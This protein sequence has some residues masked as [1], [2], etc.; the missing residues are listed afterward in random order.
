[1]FNFIKKKTLHRYIIVIIYESDITVTVSDIKDEKIIT[2]EE[3]NFSLVDQNSFSDELTY[4]INQKQN[5]VTKSYIITLLDSLGQGMIPTC[6]AGHFQKYSVDMKNIYNVC[7]DKKFTNYVS[8]IDIKWIQKLFAST[9]IDYIFSPFI[10]LSKMI[11]KDEINSEVK[12]FMLYINNGITL[13]VKKDSEYLFGS[14]FNIG[15]EDPLLSQLDS[16]FED[17]TEE[18]EFEIEDDFDD[19]FEFEIDDEEFEQESDYG[20]ELSMIEEDKR[21]IKYLNIALKEFYSEEIYESSFI[22]SVTIYSD[23]G[24]EQTLLEYIENELFLN[25][26]VKKIDYVNQL[27]VLAQEEVFS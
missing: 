16:S 2:S 26:Y 12:L 20:Q 17:N 7:V 8:K 1:L 15:E 27:I 5:E 4:Y 23:E 11:E 9:G 18:D 10:L 6:S 21:L 13:L 24:V 19:E 22:D 14:Y 3:E 25:T